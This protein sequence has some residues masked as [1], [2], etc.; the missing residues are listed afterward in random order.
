MEFY[1]LLNRGVDKRT[2]FLEKRDYLRFVHNLFVFNDIR[3]VNTSNTRH[4]RHLQDIG[5]PAG[6]GLPDG[7]RK[8]LVKIHFFCLM[9]NHYHLL[10]SPV[11]ENGI[12]KFMKKLNMG[13]AKYFNEKYKRS[14]AL[15]QGKYRSVLIKKDA[16]FMWIPYYIHFNPL[17]LTIPEWREGNV[18]DSRKAANY[19]NAYRWS[20]HLDY[21]GKKNFPLVTQREFFLDYF[22]DEGGYDHVMKSQLQAF[23]PIAA[24]EV[25]LE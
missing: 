20:S 1:H 12:S 24:Q 25:T 6:E 11:V 22:K 3:N 8:L 2:I 21:A 4:A 13:Y 17:D 16:H 19:L 5:C 15:F 10:V 9:P 14:G 23:D 18:R 7:S